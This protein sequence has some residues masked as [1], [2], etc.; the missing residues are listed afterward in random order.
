MPPAA[1]ITN[2]HVCGIPQHPPNPIVSGSGDT[3]VG[4]MPAARVGDTLACGDSVVQGS[5]NVMINNKLAA[6]LGDSTA[7]GGKIIDG[8]PTVI[9]GESSQTF[10]L[11]LAAAS[12]A[13]FCEECE[14]A[15]KAM[16][17]E[18][19]KKKAA[20]Q[21][22]SPPPDSVVKPPPS[23]RSPQD[24]PQVKLDG[25]SPETVA[26][27]A[28][29]GNTPEQRAAR[30]EVA[31]AFYAQNAIEWVP[32]DKRDDKGQRVYEKDDGNPNGIRQTVKEW[33]PK[34]IPAAKIRSHIKGIDFS[35]PVTF[36]PQPPVPSDLKQWQSPGG[37]QGNYYAHDGT[38]CDELGIHHSAAGK[39]QAPQPKISLP[40]KMSPSTPYLKSTSGPIHDTWSVYR[41]AHKTNGGGT[42]YFV[43][44]NAHVKKA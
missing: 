39:G 33:V 8:F 38:T 29:P 9:I 22:V 30:A 16:E 27:A 19:R 3:I 18:E 25:V 17:E 32:V 31:R 35:K 7:H 24:K 15:R 14:K 12:G 28:K 42:Q 26:L 5:S 2:M 13:P 44:D 11:K 37:R 40:Y 34:P 41:R 43:P 36:G 6:R 10:T 20:E 1:R 4:Y 21:K 23:A